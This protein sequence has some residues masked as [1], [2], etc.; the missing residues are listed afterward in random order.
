MG[1]RMTAGGSEVPSLVKSAVSGNSSSKAAGSRSW[2][3]VFT[4]GA[5]LWFWC[6]SGKL[7]TP[8]DQHLIVAD[9]VDEHG[10]VVRMAAFRAAGIQFALLGPQLPESR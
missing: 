1:E 9:S 3:I 8:A 10:I 7:H 5:T 6:L 2:M 4:E